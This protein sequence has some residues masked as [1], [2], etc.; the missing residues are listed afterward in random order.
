MPQ[1]VRAVILTAQ[2]I[3]YAAVRTHLT[4]RREETHPQGTIYERGTFTTQKYQWEIGIVQIEIGNASAASAAERA[5]AHFAP[6]VALFVGIADGFKD[7]RPGDVVV[8]TKIYGYEAGKAYGGTIFLPRPD[9]GQSSYRLIERA[10]ADARKTDWHNRIPGQRTTTVSG[11]RVLV[12]PIAAGE[13]IVSSTRSAIFQLLQTTYGDTLAIETEGRG[14]L[15]AAHENEQVQAL[16]IRGIT[17]LIINKRK[18]ESQTAQALAA[19]HASAFAFELLANLAIPQIAST[20]VQDNL[21]LEDLYINEK[22]ASPVLDITLRNAGAQMALPIRARID[23]LDIGEFYYATEDDIEFGRAVLPSTCKYKIELSPRD[24]G[25]CKTIKIAH[26]LLPNEADHFEIEL[27]QEPV[28]EMLA[29]VWYY[30]KITL[31]YNEQELALESS[32]LLL[33][34]PPV[35]I[36]SSSVQQPPHLLQSPINSTTL[37]KMAAL[38]GK[39]STSV[40]EVLRQ[41]L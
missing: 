33:S 40:E 12:G 4:S 19:H 16:V 28:D 18:H 25:R 6:S 8:A 37:R 11:P 2:P 34:I 24:K 32:P 30:L 13:K 14:F 5:I 31:L 36:V 17:D 23:I 3:E 27:D 1:P 10:K 21:R 7:V 41:F 9:V 39:K 15:L 29:Y 20:Q 22:Q 35:K 38:P 26:I